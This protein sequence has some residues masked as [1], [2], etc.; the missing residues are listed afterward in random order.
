M[1][2]GSAMLKAFS[3]S[4]AADAKMKAEHD[5]AE[6][7]EMEKGR[8]RWA[9]YLVA[10]LPWL[11]LLKYFH[12]ELG[13]AKETSMLIPMTRRTEPQTEK[14]LRPVLETEKTS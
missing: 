9:R 2:L 7:D 13:P 4:L 14:E 8:S 1:R 3:P 6:M 5:A 11:S 12:N 10:W